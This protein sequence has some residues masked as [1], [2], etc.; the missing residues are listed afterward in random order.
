M[1]PCK[2][3]TLIMSSKDM[4]T[5]KDLKDIVAKLIV[6]YRSWFRIMLTSGFHY[7]CPCSV[8]NSVDDEVANVEVLKAEEVELGLMGDTEEIADTILVEPEKDVESRLEVVMEICG[9]ADS[10][11]EGT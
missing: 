1:N 8:S 4:I 7:H 5:R 6:K 10:V 11:K 9:K 2:M 3:I